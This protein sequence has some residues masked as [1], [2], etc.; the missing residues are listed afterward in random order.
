MKHLHMLLAFLI[1]ALFLY[2]SFLVLTKGQRLPKAAKIATHVF[3][4]LIILTGAVMTMQLLSVNV[5][6]DWVWA[7]V[8]LLIAAISASAKAFKP[9]ASIQQSKMGIFVATIAYAGILTLAFIKPV[10]SF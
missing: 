10:L 3:Y 6:I 4:A 8:I 9:S 2:Q 7:K 5:P 1:I